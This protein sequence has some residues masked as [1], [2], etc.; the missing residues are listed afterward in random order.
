[1][2]G[3]DGAGK[4]TVIKALQERIPI[5]LTTIY[6]GERRKAATL[7]SP[8][9]GRKSDVPT[10]ARANVSPLRECA[11]VAYRWLRFWSILL[12]GYALAWA[13]HIVMCDRHPIEALA[14]RP[15]TTQ[16]AAAL[17]SFLFGRLMP[18]PD[19]LIVLD[20]PGDLLFARKGEND[21][22]TL[23]SQRQRYRETFTPSGAHVIS[24]AGRMETTV[25]AASA[26]VWNALKE[27]RRW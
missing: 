5:G 1:L 22:L 18:W 23:E 12:R 3:P 9:G 24:S 16:I 4:G 10:T 6:L 14:I 26:V 20:A 25:D 15:R 7:P 27:R 13:G 19:A 8:G 21:A 11:F 2:L 17:E